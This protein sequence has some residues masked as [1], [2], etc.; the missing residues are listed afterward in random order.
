MVTLFDI[1]VLAGAGLIGGICTGLLIRSKKIEN[2]KEEIEAG[3]RSYANLLERYMEL[4][5]SH[6]NL[7][8]AAKSKLSKRGP[9]R[10]KGS[11]NKPTAAKP[12]PKKRK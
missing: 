8:F 1:C 10:P 7:K 2:L 12:G 6:R 9:G 11:K 5:S 4:Y 3:D